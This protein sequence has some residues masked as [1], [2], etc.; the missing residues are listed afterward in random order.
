VRRKELNARIERLRNSLPDVIKRLKGRHA[1]YLA[2]KT[3][4][5][6]EPQPRKKRPE[7]EVPEGDFANLSVTA[8]PSTHSARRSSPRRQ[9]Q[10]QPWVSRFDQTQ[11]AR[12][13]CNTVTG[14]SSWTLPSGAV[15][16]DEVIRKYLS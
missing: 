2:T 8:P 16:V 12:Y 5:Q 15:L 4:K 11:K 3:K 7:V 9:Q 1:A 6:Q 10:E 14:Q 13:Y